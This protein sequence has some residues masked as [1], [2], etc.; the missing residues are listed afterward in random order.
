MRI[1]ISIRLLTICLLVVCSALPSEAARKR[2]RKRAKA[3]TTAVVAPIVSSATSPHTP[4]V[5][6]QTIRYGERLLGK[7][8][9]TRGIAPWPLDCS[10]YISYIYSLVGVRLPRSSAEQGVHTIRTDNPQPGDL[11]FFRGRNAKS[12]RVGHVA[13]VVENNDGDLVIMHSTNSRGIIKHRLRDDAYFRS[14]MLYAGRIPALAEQIIAIDQA[15]G[16]IDATETSRPIFDIQPPRPLS[17]WLHQ[18]R[19]HS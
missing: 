6:A 10:G 14:R 7:R 17:E 3:K 11:V 13:L 19:N 15:S 9:R 4:E 18:E 12:S 8:Y 1:H 2:K 16:A 5:V